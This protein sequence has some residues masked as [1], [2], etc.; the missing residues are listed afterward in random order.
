MSRTASGRTVCFSAAVASKACLFVL[1]RSVNHNVLFLRYSFFR[2]QMVILSKN[3]D[4]VDVD[5]ESLTAHC[6]GMLVP[7]MRQRALKGHLDFRPITS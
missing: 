6:M 7:K 5:E 4:P 2:S 1:L 3:G